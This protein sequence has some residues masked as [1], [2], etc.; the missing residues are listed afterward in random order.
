MALIGRVAALYLSE[1]ELPSL[2]S[3]DP[4]V[5][6]KADPL[7]ARRAVDVVRQSQPQP[8]G[9]GNT[10]ESYWSYEIDGQV[11]RELTETLTIDE[12]VH[13]QIQICEGQIT[14]QGTRTMRSRLARIVHDPVHKA[15]IYALVAALIGG[16]FLIY[17][18]RPSSHSDE[19]GT[20]SGSPNTS[21]S[22]GA[23]QS[24]VDSSWLNSSNL[25][26]WRLG[27]NHVPVV[28]NNPLQLRIDDRCNDPK[29]AD[30]KKDTPTSVY[31]SSS[32]DS[33]KVGEIADGY[34]ITVRCY[35][36]QGDDTSDAIGNQ[37]SIWLGIDAPHGFI[38]NVD[39][40]GGFTAPNSGR[41]AFDGAEW[42]ASRAWTSSPSNALP[43][44]RD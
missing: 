38:P 36:S 19:S 15:G 6:A 1:A 28:S 29:Q 20:S 32:R 22:S 26:S 11:A 23:A 4:A 21:A 41:T 9:S 27:T 18:T 2:K 13:R 8:L 10:G 42:P 3:S 14:A 44:A 7:L 12:Y 39:I 43:G 40:G 5:E 24:N 33:G 30:P 17:T 16:G 34:L 37:S 25:C 31:A 35:D